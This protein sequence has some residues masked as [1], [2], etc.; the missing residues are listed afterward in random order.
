MQHC[1][2]A[3]VCT[4]SGLAFL[5][6]FLLVRLFS[7]SF[8][9][10][11]LVAPSGLWCLSMVASLGRCT[12][13][14]TIVEVKQR[15][16]GVRDSVVDTPAQLHAHTVSSVLLPCRPFDVSDHAIMMLVV[17]H[18]TSLHALHR[19]RGSQQGHGGHNQCIQV[20][21]ALGY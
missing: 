2:A 5:A 9:R 21:A 13:R 15:Y 14:D 3:A 11:R 6:S 7:T 8:A 18:T 17:V 4:T 20:T 10:S 16:L 19:C 12:S 1:R